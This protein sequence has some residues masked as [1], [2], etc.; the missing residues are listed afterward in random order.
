MEYDSEALIQA[1]IEHVIHGNTNL[2]DHANGAGPIVLV[3]GDGVIVTDSTGKDYIDGLA[4]LWNTNIG[5]GRKEIAAAVAEQMDQIAYVPTI[6]GLSNVP[7]IRLA[8]K[9]SQVTPEGIDRFYFACGGAEANET[10]IKMVRYFHSV[11]G[12]K[13]KLKIISRQMAYHGVASTTMTVTG[14]PQFWKHFGPPT[15]YVMHVPAP[16]CYRCAFGKTKENCAMDCAMAL[17]SAIQAEGPDSIAA[18]IGEPVQGAGGVIV[19]PDEYWPLVSEI[20]SRYGVVLIVDE[21]ITGF[22]RTGT[23]FGSQHWGIKPDIMSMAKGITSAYQPLAAVG[24]SREFFSGMAQPG[25]AF[26]HSY[27][28]SGHPAVCAAALKNIEILEGENLVARAHEMGQYMNDRLAEL[29]DLPYVGETRGL[30]LMAAV[31]FVADKKTKARFEPRQKF[32]AQLIKYTREDG[33]L[34]RAGDE[35]LAVSP[36]LVVT[37][38][39]IDRMVAIIKSALLRIQV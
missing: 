12:N 26:M 37:R 30:G 10:A 36:P 23:Y 2:Y 16:Y 11:Q 39:Q 19:P 31:E 29:R 20:C 5:H 25:E 38:D 6:F 34:S 9:L 33:L 17:E 8:E 24:V 15:P 4:G 18:F 21:V 28:Y 1:D 14:L 35:W 13:D 22:G 7:T 32:G 27:T 3:K